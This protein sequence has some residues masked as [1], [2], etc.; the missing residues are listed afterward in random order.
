MVPVPNQTEFER[1]H[2]LEMY[3]NAL[4]KTL[5]GIGFKK[6]SFDRFSRK[7]EEGSQA[8]TI[9]WRSRR[10]A[11][12]LWV[13]VTPI[14]HSNFPVVKKI[15]KLMGR[16]EDLPSLGGALG[17][18]TPLKSM[19]E[20]WI[21]SQESVDAAAIETGQDI[22]VWGTLFWKQ[23]ESIESTLL[24]L[25]SINK[26]PSI[27]TEAAMR[28]LKEGMDAAIECVASWPQVRVTAEE[29]ADMIQA[30]KGLDSISK[31]QVVQPKKSGRKG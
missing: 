9:V 25:S 23:T 19:K 14:V 16:D 30:L 6:T 11:G 8:F 1:K 15:A 12:V 29:R 10:E 5:S 3:M 13:A 27:E 22:S 18:F 26:G 28:Y 7:T 2:L 21:S 17:I 4:S 31:E 20:L 24:N